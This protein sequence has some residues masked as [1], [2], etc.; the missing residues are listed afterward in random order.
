[1][2]QLR[3][4][5]VCLVF[6][7]LL[8]LCLPGGQ[9]L[10]EV[11]IAIVPDNP[12]VNQWCRLEI[13]VLTRDTT[14]V[15]ELRLLDFPP[16]DVLYMAPLREKPV[17]QIRDERG[18]EFALRRFSSR[19]RP[20]QA[21]AIRRFQPELRAVVARHDASGFMTQWIDQEITQILPAMAIKVSRLPDAGRPDEFQG[22]VG[23]FSLRGRIEPEQPAVGDLVRLSVEITGEGWL[24][25]AEPVFAPSVTGVM[26]YAPNEQVRDPATRLELER[27]FVVT[28]QSATAI[29]GAVFA[30]Y[31]PALAAYKRRE[32]GDFPIHPRPAPDAVAPLRQLTIDSP[33]RRRGIMPPF[34]LF[35]SAAFRE[36]AIAGLIVLVLLTAV[37]RL[38][39]PGGHRYRRIIRLGALAVALLAGTMIYLRSSRLSVRLGRDVVGRL[40]PSWQSLPVTELPS[41]ESLRVL[42]ADGQWM[43]IIRGGQTAW[44]H[45]QSVEGPEK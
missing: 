28:N 8:P 35:R 37:S 21:G 22:A 32:T 29:P 16:A 25:S 43:R 6:L 19:V 5:I 1:M 36:G 13:S 40:A 20:K 15:R 24:G 11:K 39:Y 31:D 44:I 17:E 41:G 38:A 26:A 2:K 4:W 14:A 34:E 27:L 10:V 33:P 9:D 3:T 12:V 18:Q 30:W 45:R 42:E 23:N 7:L